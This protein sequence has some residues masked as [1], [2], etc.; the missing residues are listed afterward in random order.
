M[1]TVAA[2]DAGP[3]GDLALVDRLFSAAGRDDPHAVLRGSAQIG[4]RHASA[5]EILHSPNFV[6]RRL[7][8]P[9]SEL[10]RMFARWLIALDGERHRKLRRAFGG[11]FTP[12]KVGDYR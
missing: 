8:A 2:S 1:A 6:P 4:C 7:S 10:F 5:R 12:R 9:E 11:E 3:A